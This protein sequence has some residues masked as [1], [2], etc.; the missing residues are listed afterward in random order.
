MIAERACLVAHV[1]GAYKNLWMHQGR[2]QE[3]LD[4]ALFDE[5][6]IASI[7]NRCTKGAT[8]D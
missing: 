4:A 7:W 2:Q 8:K 5:G 1:K 3:P 6:A